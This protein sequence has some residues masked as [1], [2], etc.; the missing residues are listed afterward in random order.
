MI[1]HDT[2]KYSLGGALK[3]FKVDQNTSRASQSIFYKS[4]KIY[5]SKTP[6]ASETKQRTLN[7]V[8]FS[9]KNR[10]LKDFQKT[11][12]LQVMGQLGNIYKLKDKMVS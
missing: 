5:Q 11:Q 9:T 8:S 6:R 1:G 12:H 2:A 3:G 10:V 4:H 7:Q